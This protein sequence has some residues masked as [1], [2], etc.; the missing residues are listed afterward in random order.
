MCVIAFSPKG[1]DAP[2]INQIKDMFEANPDG[3]GYA[4]NGKNG[5]VYYKK[6]F[7]KVEDLLDELK[8]LKRWKDTNL[9]IH[10]RIGTAGKNDEYTCHPFEISTDYKTLRKTAGEGP[11][12]FHN[13]ILAEGGK[14][15]EHS[16][17]TQDF[18]SAF[19][20]I[21]KKYGKSKVRDAILNEIVSPSKMLIMYDK[22]RYKMYGNWEKDGKIL[23][24]N[25]HY[26]YTS[27]A[28]S[29]AT[30]QTPIYD[31]YD[32]AWHREYTAWWDKKK[33]ARDLW[34][35]VEKENILWLPTQEQLDSMLE[36]ADEIVGTNKVRKDGAIYEYSPIENCIWAETYDEG[37]E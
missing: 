29:Y 7:M 18:V 17:D 19:A 27:I 24:S 3:A 14:L 5:K 6:G 8:P 35:R 22:N 28:T 13:G 21:L 37:D 15:N 16:S 20:P 2:T 25:T 30:Y 36:I 1:T 26:K 33:R 23:V 4:Y 10:F 34:D 12:L 11:V 32:E 9:A 31:T